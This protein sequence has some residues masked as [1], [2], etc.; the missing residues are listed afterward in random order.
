MVGGGRTSE[1][2][3]KGKP[4]K[5]CRAVPPDEKGRVGEDINKGAMG[6][7]YGRRRDEPSRRTI[8]QTITG[9]RNDPNGGHKAGNIKYHREKRTQSTTEGRKSLQKGGGG[10]DKGEG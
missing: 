5:R 6:V 9:F 3:L 10:K 4:G 7:R 1:G 8:A 2:Q